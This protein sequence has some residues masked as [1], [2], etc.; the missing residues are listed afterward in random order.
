M[1]GRDL[2]GEAQAESGGADRGNVFAVAISLGVTIL[3]NVV[4]QIAL[5]R[6]L[7][8]DSL[9]AYAF[10]VTVVGLFEFLSTFNLP[11]LVGR[12]VAQ[13]PDT[14]PRV[15]GLGLVTTALLSCAGTVA[16]VLYA[17][18]RDGR[19][20]VVLATALAGVALG[21]FALQLVSNAAFQGLRR[22]RLG[23]PAVVIGRTTLMV[24]TLAFLLAGTDLVGVFVARLLAMGLALA[25]ITRAFQRRVGAVDL[26]FQWREVWDL[27]R[28]GWPFAQHMLFAAIYLAADVLILKEFFD[29]H[30]VGIYK[31]ATL[32]VLQLPLASSL[33]SKVLFPRMVSHLDD[34]FAAGEELSYASRLLL[35]VSVPMTV[36][37]ICLAAPLVSFLLGKA[38]LPAVWPMIVLFMGLSLRFLKNL[39]GMALSALDRQPDRAR[40]VLLA[41]VFNVGTNLVF[42]PYYGALGAA[43]TTT[44]S[45][46]LLLGWNIT[47]L[48]GVA[49]GVAWWAATWRTVLPAVPMVIGILLVPGWHVLARIVLGAVIYL[50]S[51]WLTGAWS[52]RDLVRLARL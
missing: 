42:I 9:G 25:V 12:K 11:I 5:A 3:A 2:A 14:A 19:G 47:R 7:G 49:D 37:G 40:G 8:V 22:Q 20:Q 10:I 13:A 28:E 44:A 17:W 41:A 52:Y 45:E 26:G 15:V 4:V 36:G 29:D 6:F 24:A 23:V 50:G 51:S 21:V 18:A 38:F 48:R 34:R 46:V 1:A 31:A 27:V 35:T 39:T 30:E 32:L 33:V 43:A 16:M